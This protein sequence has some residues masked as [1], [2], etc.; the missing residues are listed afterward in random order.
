MEQH[1]YEEIFS[2]LH[3]IEQRIGLNSTT[4]IQ[5][6]Y[7]MTI[8]LTNM[9]TDLKQRIAEKG[10][11]DEKDEIYFFK[12]VKPQIL[13]KLIYYN[14]LYRIETACPASKGKI[15]YKYLASHIDKLQRHGKEYSTESEFYRYY[16][17]GR[18][19][20]DWYYFRIGNIELYEGLN[21]VVFEID[22]HFSTYYDYKVARFIS[23]QLLLKYLIKRMSSDDSNVIESHSLNHIPND[24]LWTDSKS[25][26]IELVYA[27]HVSGSISNGRIGISKIALFFEGVFKIKLGDLHHTFHRMKDRSG[28][29]TAFINQLA[30][31]LEKY[32]NKDLD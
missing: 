30:S 8:H 29:K 19:D 27:L 20:K 18:T 23:D 26:L 4:V 32:M 10:F 24:L 22:L 13:G 2:K 21:S 9:L 6:S 12:Y 1:I 16:K 15:L 31:N 5:E 3:V 14:K 25:A 11:V 28:D 17:S 7:Q